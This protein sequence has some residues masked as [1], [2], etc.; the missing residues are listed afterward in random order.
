MKSLLLAGVVV[1]LALRVGAAQET[2]S[3]RLN[4]LMIAVDDL[5][6]ELG[7]YGNSLVKS[8]N[9]DRLAAGGTVFLHAYCQQ[10]VCSP[11]RSSLLTGKRPDA[12]KVWDLETHF[13]VALPDVVTLPQYFKANGYHCAALNKIYHHGFEDGRSWSEPHWYPNGQT[14]DTDPVDWTKRIVKKVA[15]GVTE[16]SHRPLPADNDKPNAGRPGKAAKGPAFEVSAKSDDELPDGY[17]AAEAVKRLHE[18]K[19]ADQPFFLAVGFLKPHLPFVAPKK[20]WDLYDPAKIPLPAIDHLPQGAPKFAGHTNGELHSYQNVPKDNPIPD[21][22]ARSLRHGYYACIS[23][24][25]A[26]VGRLLDALEAE[27]LS[28][29]T[30][31][32]LWGD[33]GW[34]LGDHGL[35]HKHTNF[36]LATR[37]PLIIRRPHQKTAGGK[38]DTPV[39]FVDIYPTIADLC[40][41][42]I[43]PG[44]DGVTLKP[45]LDD[46]K[47]DLKK[48]AVSQYPRGGAQTDNRPL[49][50]YSIRDARWRLTLWLDRRDNAL[51]ATELY[52]EQND[53]A[54]TVN[55]ADVAENKA[56]IAELQTHLPK[57]STEKPRDVAPPAKPKIDR[58][59]LFEK[60]DTNHDGRLSLD[61]F[62]ANQADGKAAKPRFAQWDLDKDGFLS[63]EEFVAAGGKSQAAKVTAPIDREDVPA[64]AV[65]H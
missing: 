64:P 44:V 63:R 14:I 3:K 33:H 20:Y 61:E 35:W 1:L 7:C 9:I 6:P 50:G 4:V 43:P 25:D 26:Q 52:D 31:V 19:R 29:N 57:K 13:R 45:C 17:T 2:S 49:M 30:V 24:T 59:A 60:K 53:P 23:Y 38:C 27:G 40:G 48:T 42:P 8:P 62:M 28:E 37:A 47:I 55:V 51:A 11:S 10:A 15:A 36:E 16:S 18:L 21:D 46:P 32:V 39:E 22:F 34:Q 12:T 56:I 41:L 65:R 58:A 5:R 54:E